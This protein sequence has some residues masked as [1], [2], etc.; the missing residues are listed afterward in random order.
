MFES[1]RVKIYTLSNATEKGS[2]LLFNIDRIIW[3]KLL[4]LISWD[5]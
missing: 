1:L 3:N 4:S 5:P 2:E